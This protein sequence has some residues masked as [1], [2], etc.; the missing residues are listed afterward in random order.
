MN[1]LNALTNKNLFST[2]NKNILQNFRRF[3][4]I[5]YQL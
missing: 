4:T 2:F 3:V 5:S 1:G